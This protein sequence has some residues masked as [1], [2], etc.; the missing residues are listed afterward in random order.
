MVDVD[1]S[2]YLVTDST[3][4]PESST[5]L[6]QVE[7]AINNGATLIQLREKLLTTR[8]FIT[9]AEQVHELTKKKRYPFN[10]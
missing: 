6:K 1:Y 7:A 9:R 8:Q 10:Y 5:F 3:M 4:I 2:L